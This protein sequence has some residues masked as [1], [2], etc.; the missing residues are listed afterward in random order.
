VSFSPFHSLQTLL[1]SPLLTDLARFRTR[2]N[3]DTNAHFPHVFFWNEARM[4]DEGS[5]PYNHCDRKTRV[6][7]SFKIEHSPLTL[8]NLSSFLLVPLLRY[9]DLYPLP[10][11]TKYVTERV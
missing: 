8:S 7:T 1:V 3:C 10:H 4:T 2:Q 11:S 6:S 5:S 9:N